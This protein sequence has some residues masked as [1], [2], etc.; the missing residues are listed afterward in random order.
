MATHGSQ[1][2]F[3]WML[4]DN[5]VSQSHTY[6]WTQFLF[7][8]FWWFRWEEK[9]HGSALT[10]HVSK[11]Q[12]CC[13]HSC[14]GALGAWHGS[15][16][17]QGAVSEQVRETSKQTHLLPYLY[18]LETKTKR[19]RKLIKNTTALNSF[20]RRVPALGS[21]PLP[22]LSAAPHAGTDACVHTLHCVYGL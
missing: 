2:Q 15:K 3:L 7:N 9:W 22:P 6:P 13:L 10:Y 11:S 16:G 18:V 8:L 12:L 4:R 1:A 14:I 21:Q 5:Y 20:Q 17:R 19:K